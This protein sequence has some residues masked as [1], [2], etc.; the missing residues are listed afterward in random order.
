MSRRDAKSGEEG[1]F[2]PGGGH[3]ILSEGM[4]T[5]KILDICIHLVGVSGKGKAM[6][7]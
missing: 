6:G 5:P 1:E 7:C 3:F 2:I 4:V